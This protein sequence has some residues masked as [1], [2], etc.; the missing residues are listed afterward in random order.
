MNIFDFKDQPASQKTDT[1]NYRTY[2]R[3]VPSKSLQPY[4]DARPV[5][6]KYSIMPIVDPRTPPTVNLKQ[7]PTY[8]I[9]N[10][11]NPGNDS[12]PWSGYASNV[13]NESILRNQIYALQDCSQSIYVPSSK[14][15][16]YHV[17]WKEESIQQPFPDL[18]QKQTF[19][20]NSNI[21]N[22][23]NLGY[24]LFNNATRQQVKDI[25]C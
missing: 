16:L 1:T 21:D 6:T 15:D 9:H 2:I 3:N 18:F 4:L 7:M 5:S 22:S 13:N 25:K 19:N 17:H 20:S 12:G 24:A 23:N 10:T 14:S 8:N 11:F